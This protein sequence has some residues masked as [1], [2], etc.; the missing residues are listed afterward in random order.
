M[1]IRRLVGRLAAFF[2]MIQDY[3]N[4]YETIRSRV[5]N[6]NSILSEAVSQFGDIIVELN[7]DQMLLGRDTDGKPFT[8]SY[9]ADPYFKTKAQAN[10]YAN[11]KYALESQHK[12]RL[13]YPQLYPDKNKDTPNLIVI[14][15]F[16]DGMF[17]TVNGDTHRIDSTYIDSPDIEDKYNKKV[18][19]LTKESKEFFYREFLR[20]FLIENIYGM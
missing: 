16:Q 18:F 5:L 11:M 4:R 7:K 3:L 12:S 15:N 1:F 14:G 6:F 8:P 19:G 20:D 13:N 17:I 2:Y 9:L 10:W